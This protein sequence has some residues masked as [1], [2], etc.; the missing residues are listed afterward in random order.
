MIKKTRQKKSLNLFLTKVVVVF[1]AKLLTTFFEVFVAVTSLF[2]FLSNGSGN[3][4]T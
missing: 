2:F 4:V 3:V 1:S